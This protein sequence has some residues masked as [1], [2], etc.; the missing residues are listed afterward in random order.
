MNGIDL[1]FD[2]KFLID[3]HLSISQLFLP[4]FICDA[5]PLIL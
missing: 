2:L 3:G 5:L 4:G 1:S